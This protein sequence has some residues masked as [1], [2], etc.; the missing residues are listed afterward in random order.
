M[1][2]GAAFAGA[3]GVG[4]VPRTVDA[5]ARAG[6]Y[7]PV[8]VCGRDEKL[9]SSLV[10]EA[11]GG[12]V[13]GWTDEMPALMAACDALVENYRASV[14]ERQGLGWDVLHAVNPRL[15]Y[16]KLSSQ[17]DSGPERDYG[18]L[19]STLEQTGGL[20]SVTRHRDGPPLMTNG[21]YPDP[22]AGIMAVGALLAEMAMPVATYL[23]QLRQHSSRIL[24]E[25][26]APDYP[27]SVAATWSLAMARPSATRCRERAKRSAKRAP[28]SPASRSPRRRRAE[29]SA[30][31]IPLWKKR[32][33][34]EPRG[35]SSCRS[36][37]T[38]SPRSRRVF[39]S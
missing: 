9:R 36:G 11:L 5:I 3:W 8:T 17:G 32:L 33:G 4:D 6:N 37:L 24:S 35:K 19:G 28:F 12:T 30:F 39:S 10:E 1:A 16:L 23:E 38:S 27:Y 13:L 22:V 18:S 2:E 25:N 34:W 26:R 7:H 31:S 21:T 15:V 14:M 29:R 20:V